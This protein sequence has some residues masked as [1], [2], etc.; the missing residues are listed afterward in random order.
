MEREARLQ[1]DLRSLIERT[2]KERR[3]HGLEITRVERDYPV[4]GREAD[5]VIFMRGDIP[6]MFIETKRKVGR[7]TLFDPLD[8]SVVGQVMS[9]AALWKRSHPEHE[10]PFVATSNPEFIAIFITPSATSA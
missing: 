5:L 2:T 3:F 10:I 7:G 1:D 4:D 8:A 6:F 9:Y